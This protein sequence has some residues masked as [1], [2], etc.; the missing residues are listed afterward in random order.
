MCPF[1]VWLC[2]ELYK[3]HRSSFTV[4]VCLPLQKSPCPSQQGNLQS[5]SLMQ[6]RVCL[7]PPCLPMTTSGQTGSSWGCCVSPH[8]TVSGTS[9]PARCGDRNYS[10]L[11]QGLA[12]W[13][14]GA[15]VSCVFFPERKSVHSPPP[16]AV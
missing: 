1:V 12:G 15:A 6:G 3:A 13:A 9:T 7:T 2:V 5:S 11:K 4:E 14:S 10:W 16:V 8:P